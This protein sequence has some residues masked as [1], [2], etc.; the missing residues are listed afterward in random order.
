MRIVL[1]HEMDP[2]KGGCEFVSRS[3]AELPARTSRSPPAADCRSPSR[4]QENFFSTTPPELINDGIYRDIALAL[5]TPPHR[6]VSLSL[7]A[8]ALG[9]TK[10]RPPAAVSTACHDRTI[11]LLF[12]SIARRCAR[13]RRP[14]KG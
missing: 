6:E 7:V 4:A 9:A 11:A 2:S 13:S 10:V 8:Q 14:G 3:R 12:P 5:H 1:I